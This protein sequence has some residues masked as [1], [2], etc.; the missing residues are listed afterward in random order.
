MIP[1]NEILQMAHRRPNPPNEELFNDKY[2]KKTNF[3]HRGSHFAGYKDTLLI[4]HQYFLET[5]DR[6]LERNMIILEDQAVLQSACLAHPEICAYA[7][8]SQVKDC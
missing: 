2:R 8:S 5:I 6:F 1:P 3:Y 4:F 7:P